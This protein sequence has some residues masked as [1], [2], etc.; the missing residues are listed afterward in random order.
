[1]RSSWACR[2]H[3][4]RLLGSYY[5][6]LFPRS[7]WRCSRPLPSQLSHRRTKSAQSCPAHPVAVPAGPKAYSAAAVRPAVG[8]NSNA[9]AH[10]GVPAE[11][12][13]LLELAPAGTF[14]SAVRL[15]L[16]A[17]HIVRGAACDWI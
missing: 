15:S 1:M 4:S 8:M 6:R 14:D 17:S 13:R 3:R 7:A 5:L 10:Q 2:V 16:T 12:V 11:I 9:E